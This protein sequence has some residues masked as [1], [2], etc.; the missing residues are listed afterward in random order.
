MKTQIVGE[1]GMEGRGK[2]LALTGCD[3]PPIRQ[4]QRGFCVTPNPG[5]DRSANE[6]QVVG[7]L[8][9]LKER[10]CDLDF[11]GVNLAPESIALDLHVHQSEQGLI[12]P[13]FFGE[14][15]RAGAGAPDGMG[16]PKSSQGLQKI[17]SHH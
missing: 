17:I 10:Y 3:R 2:E 4:A 11:E 7:H 9:N 12:A 14:Q 16:L 1:L 8:R 13:D 5:D 15:D 6:G